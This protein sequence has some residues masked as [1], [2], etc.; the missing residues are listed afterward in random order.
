MRNACFLAPLLGVAAA[1]GPCPPLG[2]VF[3]APKSLANDDVFQNSLARLKSSIEETLST[4]TGLPGSVSPNDTYSI[5]IFSTKDEKPLLDYH[6]RGGGVVGNRTIDGDSVYR[7][8]SITKIFTVYLLLLQAGEGIFA[9]PV[10]K[11]LPELEA[12]AHWKG[13]SVGTVASYLS[14]VAAEGKN[15]DEQLERF[16]TECRSVC[17]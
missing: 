6:R 4:G 5:Q 11:Y 10:T 14:G 3:P 16:K 12:S 15:M 13:V 9:D 2:P 17:N 7:I 1:A 8:A